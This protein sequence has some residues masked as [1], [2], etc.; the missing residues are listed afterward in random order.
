MCST[1]SINPSSSDYDIDFP[2]L[3]RCKKSFSIVP[4]S[5]EYDF[6]FPV[7]LGLKTSYCIPIYVK[8]MSGELI[9]FIVSINCTN[10]IL[11]LVVLYYLNSLSEYESICEYDYILY[12]IL[13][14]E[15]ENEII[16]MNAF[17]LYPKQDEVFFIFIEP[18]I[19]SL[20]L[21]K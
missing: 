2:P 3:P 9:R 20:Q 15:K 10:V 13:N 14:N 11:Y 18:N 19:Y 8:M 7:L 5:S 16:Q 17:Y 6:H 1:F 21:R 4:F 12:R